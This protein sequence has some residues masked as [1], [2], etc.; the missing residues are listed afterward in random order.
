MSW[1]DWGWVLLGG[2]AVL[3]YPLFIVL[4]PVVTLVKVWRMRG[5]KAAFQEAGAEAAGLVLIGLG[6]ALLFGLITGAVMLFGWWAERAD[7]LTVP[8]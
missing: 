3:W 1:A 5:P 2:V 4:S 7:R 8:Y 6:F